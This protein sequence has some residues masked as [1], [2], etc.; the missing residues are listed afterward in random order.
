[1]CH[2]DWISV[3]PIFADMFCRTVNRWKAKRFM[4]TFK[5]IKI[6]NQEGLFPI[7]YMIEEKLVIIYVLASKYREILYQMEN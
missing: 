1:M 4:L 6:K 5:N 3:F 2:T 7:I